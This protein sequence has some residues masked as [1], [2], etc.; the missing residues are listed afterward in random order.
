M[1]YGN[2]SQITHFSFSAVEFC[3][4]S[5]FFLNF[6]F[7]P[8]SF[9]FFSMPWLFCW[10]CLWVFFFLDNFY[11]STSCCIHYIT[12]EIPFVASIFIWRTE[13]NII[14]SGFHILH[15]T[16]S[17]RHSQNTTTTTAAINVEKKKKLTHQNI[18]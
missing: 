8:F 18:K 7:I 13:K 1:Q 12:F 16:Q 17:N 10:S 3:F 6:V 15:L 14:S 5:S 9:S 11:I 4:F 2:N